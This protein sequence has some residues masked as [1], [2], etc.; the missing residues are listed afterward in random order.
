MPVS[1]APATRNDAPQ[2]EKLTRVDKGLNRMIASDRGWAI[3]DHLMQW[4]L[5]PL[6]VLVPCL[7]ALAGVGF[8]AMV[9]FGVSVIEFAGGLLAIAVLSSLGQMRPKRKPRKVT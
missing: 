5:S 2:A 8:L 3:L 7:L 9:V 1:P 4:S 6:A